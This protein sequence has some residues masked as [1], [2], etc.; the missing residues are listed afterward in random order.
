MEIRTLVS[1]LDQPHLAA[2]HLH[3]WG[4]SDVGRG[5]RVLLELAETGLTLDLLAALSR[6]LREHLPL[7]PDPDAALA[8]LRRYLFAVRSPIGLVAL[9]DREPSAMPALLSA[10]SLGPHWMEL[11]INDPDAFDVLLQSEGQPID[12]AALVGDLLAELESF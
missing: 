2:E 11:L 1:I 9:F 10:L 8:A 12:D 3:S 7:A 4:L 6:Q 5:Q